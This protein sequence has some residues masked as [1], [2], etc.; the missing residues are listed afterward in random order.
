MASKHSP[1]PWKI[2][3]L[4]MPARTHAEAEANKQLAEAAPD[5]AEALIARCRH[6]RLESEIPPTTAT[7]TACPSWAALEKAGLT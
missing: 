7:C 6:C 2:G 3:G 1:G 4:L 5:L